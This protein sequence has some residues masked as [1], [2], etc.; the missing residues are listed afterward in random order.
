MDLVSWKRKKKNKIKDIFILLEIFSSAAKM[1]LITER[2]VVILRR[3]PGVLFHM[4]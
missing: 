1:V 2:T 4:V 3:C